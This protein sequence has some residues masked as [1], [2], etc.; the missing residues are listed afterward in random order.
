MSLARYVVS[1]QRRP[2]L[3]MVGLLAVAGL[4]EGLGIATLLPILQA[5]G[6]GGGTASGL[7]AGATRLV[8][9]LGAGASLGVLL[10]AVVVAFALKAAVLYVAG[11]HVGRIVARVEVDLLMR[12]LRGVARAEW[13]HLSRYPHG[14]IANAVSAETARTGAAIHMLAHSFAGAILVVVYV[15]LALLV[16]WS[17]ALG[18][19]AVGLGILVILRGRIT[20]TRTAA[21]DQVRILRT[22]MARITDALPSLKSLRATSREQYLLRRLEDE[23]RAFLDARNRGATAGEA[24]IRAREPLLVAAVAGGLW[25][26]ATLTSLD[27]AAT[28]VLALLFYRTVTSITAIQG[29]WVS[30]VVG[31]AS[32]QSLMEHIEAAE[33]E[34]E[35]AGSAP[36]VEPTPVKLERD[37]RLERVFFSYGERNVL[38]GANA[39]LEAGTLVVLAGPSGSGKTTLVDVVTGLLRPSG[40]RVLADGVDLA[41][42]DARAWR[43]TVGYVP[44]EPMLFN[45]TIR[46]NVALG[47]PSIDDGQVE[48]ALRAAVAWDFVSS[49]P[50][51]V[52]HDIGEGGKALSGGERQ[53]L[54]IARAL[55]TSPSV[56]ILDEPTSGLDRAAEAQV[57]AAIASLK[58]RLT[59]LIASHQ[60][61]VQAIADEV[62]YLDNGRIVSSRR[63]SARA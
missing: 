14:F 22:I 57:C 25:L 45:D 30:V 50:S 31:E 19:M 60:P 59:I 54:A 43:R 12:L 10:A 36:S 27:G 38:G 2:F 32:F 24:V 8:E 4:L 47:D 18:A 48:R 23:A 40:G 15:T 51:G 58:G 26:A 33:R 21:G 9:Y 44:Q 46:A 63:T 62:W 13:R 34:Q 42:L 49:L 3:V 7:G 17:L 29:R 35:P 1:S 52:E 55:V 53:R 56:L 39:V 37:L 20:E 28:L 41:T 16:S 11:I 6:S 61:A 5:I